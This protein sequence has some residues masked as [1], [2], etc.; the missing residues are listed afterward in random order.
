M[1]SLGL[2]CLAL[3]AIPFAFRNVRQVYTVN[4]KGA[5]AAIAQNQI[6]SIV[7]NFTVI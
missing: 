4:M 1:L 7:A 3:W 2:R 5:W 6:P